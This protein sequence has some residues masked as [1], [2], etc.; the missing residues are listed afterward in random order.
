MRRWGL[1]YLGRSTFP[2]NLSECEP[3]QAFTFAHRERRDIRKAF[4]VK[5]RLAAELQ[6]GF[7]RLTDTSLAS[8]AYVPTVVLHHLG[9]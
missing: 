8:V 1:V 3:H 9:R 6:F 5:Y 7:L 4:R 2:K